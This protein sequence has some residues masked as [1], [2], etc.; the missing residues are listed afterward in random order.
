MQSVSIIVTSA[1]LLPFPKCLQSFY[2]DWFTFVLSVSVAVCS[3][4]NVRM[5]YHENFI[6]DF[7]A[8]SKENF[9][10]WHMRIIYTIINFFID[11]NFRYSL[12]SSDWYTKQT[13]VNILIWKGRGIARRDEYFISKYIIVW[14]CFLHLDAYVIFLVTFKYR[15][16][17][18]MLLQ[19][20]HV[21]FVPRRKR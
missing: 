7:K 8:N 21:P 6:V 10:F 19:G 17:V 11:I 20:K 3:I 5:Y 16:L 4:H 2:S 14:N 12:F 1:A 9:F 18:E 13:I 15:Q